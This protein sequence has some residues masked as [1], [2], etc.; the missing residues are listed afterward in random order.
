MSYRSELLGLPPDVLG[1]R[2]HLV[3]YGVHFLKEE[4][5]EMEKG[6]IGTKVAKNI[7][8]GKLDF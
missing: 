6:F 3:D 5:R 8:Q 7:P 4:E 1:H 2:H